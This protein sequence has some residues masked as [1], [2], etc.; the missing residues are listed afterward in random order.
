MLYRSMFYRVVFCK[1][2]IIYLSFHR[3]SDNGTFQKLRLLTWCFSLTAQ[4]LPFICLRGS[5]TAAEASR[6]SGEPAGRK[7]HLIYVSASPHPQQHFHL[8]REITESLRGY[9][10][11]G[12]TR[13]SCAELPSTSMKPAEHQETL[14]NA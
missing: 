6:R 9:Q 5:D 13:P 10:N 8:S 1:I 12:E 2:P 4:Y 14:S 7:L 11:S 3:H